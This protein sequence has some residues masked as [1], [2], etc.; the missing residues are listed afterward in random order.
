MIQFFKNY[1]NN[2]RLLYS[3]RKKLHQSGTLI[4]AFNKDKSIFVH[5]PKT[6]GISLIRSIY[7]NVNYGGHRSIQFYK[8]VFIYEDDFFSFSFVRNPWDRLYSAYMFLKKG[9][10][11]IHDQRAYKEFL[12]GY[13]DFE[14]FVMN[15]LSK[16]MI[17]SI[18]HFIPQHKFI[19]NNNNVILV[20][21]LG[22][23]ETLVNSVVELEKLM[24]RKIVLP[25]YNKT[26][27]E[28]YNVVY[29]QDMISKVHEIYITDINLF[30]YSF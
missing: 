5:I 10:M 30:G 3:E 8:Q 23:Y 29:T 1:Y 27:K 24:N 6:A 20:D 4:N 11:N 18:P 22:R 17:M 15:G 25:H 28:K 2:K 19:C 14:D 9:G 16:D 26:L 7:G 13:K 12:S 21:F